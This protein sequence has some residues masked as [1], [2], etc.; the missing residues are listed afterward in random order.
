MRM[1]QWNINR[2]AQH[3]KINDFIAKTE[4]TSFY[5]IRDN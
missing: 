1:K 2:E 4:E 3:Q 5:V